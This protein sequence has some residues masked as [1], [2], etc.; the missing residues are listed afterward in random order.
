[1]ITNKDRFLDVDFVPDNQIR[2]IGTVGSDRL[3][4]LGKQ[5]GTGSLVVSRSYAPQFTPTEKFF[6]VPLDELYAHSQDPITIEG[7]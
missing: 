4:Y 7:A 1:M 6:A 2:P 3:V 5:Q